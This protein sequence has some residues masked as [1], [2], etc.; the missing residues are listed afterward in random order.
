MHPNFREVK[1]YSSWIAVHHITNLYQSFDI[2]WIAVDSKSDSNKSLIQP[3][4]LILFMP[5]IL[6]KDF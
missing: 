2:I 3:T 4:K 5:Y 6:C 1:V